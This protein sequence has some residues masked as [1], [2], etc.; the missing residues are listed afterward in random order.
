MS[1][2]SCGRKNRPDARFCNGCGALQ[3]SA[4]GSC[5][6]TLRD[7]AREAF[8]LGSERA[9]HIG[10]I[11]AQLTRAR[12]LIAIDGVEAHR[13][14]ESALGRAEALLRTTG[15]RS[16]EPQILVERARLAGLL[17]NST[18]HRAHLAEAHRLFSEMGAT[19]Y[20]ERLAREFGT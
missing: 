14:I 11:R 13:Y 16:Y 19:G 12:V 9:R 6:T 8:R 7:E 1:C 2:P 3:A 15:A 20:A 5:G 18:H 10:E 4:C 17:S